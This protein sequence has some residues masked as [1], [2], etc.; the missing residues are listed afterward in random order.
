MTYCHVSAQ[1]SEHL[2]RIAA[3]DAF[4]SLRDE[5]YEDRC[6]AERDKIEKSSVLLAA[7]IQGL[8]EDA[9]DNDEAV[10]TAMVLAFAGRIEPTAPI[11]TSDENCAAAA[12]RIVA[13][14]I[15]HAVSQNVDQPTDAEVW[16]KI[17][18]DAAL[19]RM[20]DSD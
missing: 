8:F 2:G 10:L 6:E 15:E 18:D 20:I 7:A 12:K 14:A 19:D 13:E 4:E 11:G 3:D 5:M 17:R 9:A 16:K 1:I